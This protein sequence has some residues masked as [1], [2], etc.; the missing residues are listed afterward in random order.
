MPGAW[1]LT[2]SRRATTS[3][4]SVRRAIRS[5]SGSEDGDAWTL[6]YSFDPGDR[7]RFALEWL[8]VESDV[9]ARVESLAE[10]AFATESKLE[11]SARYSLSGSFQV[12]CFGAYGAAVIASPTIPSSCPL[13]CNVS[14]RPVDKSNSTILCRTLQPGPK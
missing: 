11:F 9:P 4:R 7:W 1:A 10:P 14:L 6:A 8:R 13:S 3:S 5:S 2:C 12:F